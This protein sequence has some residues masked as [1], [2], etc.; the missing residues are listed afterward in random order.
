MGAEEADLVSVESSKLRE[1]KGNITKN[2]KC[3]DEVRSWADRLPETTETF[4]DIL[5][6]R[7]RVGRWSSLSIGKG[8]DDARSISREEFRIGMI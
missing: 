2:R 5:H 6:F 1:V 4:V 7:I 8:H 3:V